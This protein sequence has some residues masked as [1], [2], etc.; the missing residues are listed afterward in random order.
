[1]ILATS[2]VVIPTLTRT[3]HTGNPLPHCLVAV[4]SEIFSTCTFPTLSIRRLCLTARPSTANGLM[5]GCRNRWCW[6]CAPWLQCMCLPLYL[7]T[8]VEGGRGGILIEPRFM[9]PFSVLF[10][11]NRSIL[12]ELDEDHKSL[13]RQWA[14]QAG[15]LILPK[16]DQPTLEIVQVCQVLGLFWFAVG[17][18]Q[19]HSMFTGSIGVSF[20][21]LSTCIANGWDRYCLESDKDSS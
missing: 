16:I 9:H 3:R 13:S 17:E 19:R 20:S 21:T 11:Q 7:S 18:V 12:G 14:L 1:M 8:H 2:R 4:F 5:T 15:G 6:R 10:Q